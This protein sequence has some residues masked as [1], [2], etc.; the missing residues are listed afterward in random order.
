M[1]IDRYLLE[2]QLK[3][4]NNEFGYAIY[5]YLAIFCN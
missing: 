3:N 1:K 2:Q 4:V 5:A